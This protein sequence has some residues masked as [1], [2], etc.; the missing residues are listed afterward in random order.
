MSEQIFTRTRFAKAFDVSRETLERLDIFMAC[1]ERWQRRINLVA[2]STLPQ[3]WHR[4]LADSA[5]VLTHAPAPAKTWIDLG[6]GA[7]FPGL[8]VAALAAEQ[9]PALRVTLVES[10]G[11][12]AAFL[13][14]AAQEMGLAIGVK[15]SRAEDLPAQ[16]QDIVSARALAPLPAL[17][18]LAYRFTGPSTTCLF[19]KGAHA[20]RELTAARHDWHIEAQSV[21]SLT[22][23]AATLLVLSEIAPRHDRP[24]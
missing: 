5:Q 3:A 13:A 21:V 9:R 1:L 14:T 19:L 20:D 2:R 11:R 23:P 6:A 12:K 10:D 8:V 22:D 15:S 17:L 16:P 18:P 4:H 24:R 7:G